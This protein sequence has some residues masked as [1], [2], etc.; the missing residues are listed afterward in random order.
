MILITY[1]LVFHMHLNKRYKHCEQY[2]ATN[3]LGLVHYKKQTLNHF[4]LPLNAGY[5]MKG[6]GAQW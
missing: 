1:I 2:Q 3:T 5:K 6:C 4:Y